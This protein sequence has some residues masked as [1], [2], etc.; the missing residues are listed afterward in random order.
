MPNMA[1]NWLDYQFIAKLQHCDRSDCDQECFEP[2][3]RAFELRSVPATVTKPVRNPEEHE[4]HLDFV[5]Y[6]AKHVVANDD[7]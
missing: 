5:W 3:L 6:D 2:R 7:E 4:E 1:R